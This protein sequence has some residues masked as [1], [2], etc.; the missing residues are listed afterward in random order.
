[1][2]KT[3][4]EGSTVHEEKSSLRV[5][6]VGK[7]GWGWGVVLQLGSDEQATFGVC[8]VKGRPGQTERVRDNEAKGL[9]GE[10]ISAH[11]N[12]I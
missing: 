5:G 4:F 10:G 12:P 2:F 11:V 3:S 9:L 1:M 8:R 7:P 6:V